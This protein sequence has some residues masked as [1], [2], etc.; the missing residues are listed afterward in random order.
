VER[1][2]IEIAAESPRH[3][4]VARLIRALDTYMSSLYPAESNHLLGINSLAAPSVHFL[5]ARREGEAVGCGALRIDVAGYG[6][7]KRMF[8]RSDFR[9]MSIGKRLLGSLEERARGLG[10]SCLRLETGIS[11]P[12]ALALYRA[13]GFFERGPFGQYRS[14]PLSVFMEKALP[15]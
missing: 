6:E 15:S 11:Q 10:V 12:E 7:V 5:V 4:D 9:G 14:D 1:S 13:A 8:V 2:S 3:D